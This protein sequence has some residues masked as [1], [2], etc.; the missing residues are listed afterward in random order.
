MGGLRTAQVE[1]FHR[2]GYVVAERVL[3]PQRDLQPVIDE[4]TQVLDRIAQR[5]HAAGEL[6]ETYAGLPF[7]ERAMTIAR[8]TGYLDVQPFDISMPLKRELL[9]ADAE[10]HFGPAVFDLLR[11]PRL[12]D[13]VESVLGPEIY[14]NPVQHV[15]VK[16]PERLVPEGKRNA[17]NAATGWHQ[18]QGV[19]LAEADETDMLTVWF[20]LTE[21]SERHGC[22]QVVPRS[23]VEGLR[24][25]CPVPLQ[26]SRIPDTLVPQERAVPVPMRPGSVLFMHRQTLHGSLSNLSDTIRWSFDIRYQPIGQPTG[27]PIFPGFVARSRANPASELRD[28]TA[29]YQRWMATRDHLLGLDQMP[30]LVRWTGEHAVCA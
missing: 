21:A 12:L 26:G 15:R 8:E 9:T 27:R 23:H 28:H 6:A 5:K 20:P 4:Y 17:Q 2:E 10:F 18:D 11:N 19:V 14:S 30:K 24:T 29:W 25:H 1:H 16:V 13:C 22:L 3:D 7:A